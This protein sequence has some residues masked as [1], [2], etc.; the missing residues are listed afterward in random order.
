MGYPDDSLLDMFK[1]YPTFPSWHSPNPSTFHP[2]LSHKPKP[3]TRFPQGLSGTDCILEYFMIDEKSQAGRAWSFLS[4]FSI[5][6][7]G[8]W[9]VIDQL[10]LHIR[11]KNAC[12]NGYFLR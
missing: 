7:N 8:D 1:W 11:S 9:S 3:E 4:I 12:L 10:N 2:F 5:K 6:D